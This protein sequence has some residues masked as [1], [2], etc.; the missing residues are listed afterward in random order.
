[1][2]VDENTNPKRDIYYLGALTIEALE[3]EN[4]ISLL[5]LYQSLNAKESISMHLFIF[6]LDW[7]YLIN[8]IEQENGEIRLCS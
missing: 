8:A 1:M 6:V 7:L 5:D 2:I 3:K 4:S